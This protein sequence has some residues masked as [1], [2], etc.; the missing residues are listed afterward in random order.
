MEM[1]IIETPFKIEM[2]N[3]ISRA[4]PKLYLKL[5]LG[6]IETEMKQ[7]ARKEYGNALPPGLNVV[8]YVYLL[9]KIEGNNSIYRKFKKHIIT[10]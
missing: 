10:I 2:R 5:V 4:F 7:L 1:L 8:S 9:E 6:G 3:K